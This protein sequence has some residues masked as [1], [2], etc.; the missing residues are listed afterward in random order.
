[1]ISDDLLYHSLSNLSLEQYYLSIYIITHIHT[2]IHACMHA[3]IHTYTHTYIHTYIT[4]FRYMHHFQ[5]SQLM[6][7]HPIILPFHLPWISHEHLSNAVS[8]AVGTREGGDH[9]ILRWADGADA[10]STS[11]HVTLAPGWELGPM[12][13]L[14]AFIYPVGTQCRKQ[15]PFGDGL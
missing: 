1:M 13:D 8:Q 14:S 3:Y 5:T 6:I 9:G 12:A 11:A 10:T 15:L 7:L 2:Y 4:I